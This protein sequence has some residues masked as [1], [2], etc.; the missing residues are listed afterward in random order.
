MALEA[1]AKAE[2]ERNE[3]KILNAELSEKLRNLKKEH[4]P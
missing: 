4:A 3:A 1:L 2:E